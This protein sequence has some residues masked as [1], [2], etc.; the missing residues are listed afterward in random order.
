MNKKNENAKQLTVED[1]M[2]VVGGAQ[3]FEDELDGFESE[4]PQRRSRVPSGKQRITI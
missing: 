3:A 2:S 1:L 4:G